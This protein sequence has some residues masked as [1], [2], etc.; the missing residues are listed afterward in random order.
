MFCPSCGEKAPADQ[1]F[2]RSCG[3]NLEKVTPLLND[4][5]CEQ[6]PNELIERHGNRLRN[7]SIYVIGSGLAMALALGFP[8]AIYKLF[9]NGNTIPAVLLSI[10]F[11]SLSSASLLYVIRIF[12]RQIVNEIRPPQTQP[13]IA[14]VPD[15]D[16]TLGAIPVSSVAERTTDRL[17]T[18]AV[19]E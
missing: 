7:I 9:V 1:K 13:I 12:L 5:H 4:D 11:I 2:C 18:P 8:A 14:D 3:F 19:R 16:R 17:K 6:K 15:T 10:L